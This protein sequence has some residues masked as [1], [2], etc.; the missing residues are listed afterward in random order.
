LAAA[1]A[2]SGA[3]IYRHWNSAKSLSAKVLL[4]VYFK[5]TFTSLIFELTGKKKG[6]EG[7]F[8]VS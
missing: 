4:N 8:G 5:A 3:G 6:A 7:A 1:G 2:F